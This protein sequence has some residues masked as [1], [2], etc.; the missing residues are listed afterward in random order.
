MSLTTVRW[1]ALGAGLM[2]LAIGEALGGP[3][4]IA[5][6]RRFDQANGNIRKSHRNRNLLALI[7]NRAPHPNAAHQQIQPAA[8]VLVGMLAESAPL[9]A[10]WPQ[11]IKQ[12]DGR[13]LVAFAGR[14]F[15]LQP[16]LKNQ[17]PGHYLGDTIQEGLARLE[18]LLVKKSPAG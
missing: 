10:G 2:P 11:W 8:L 7:I 13:P 4:L 14:A 6:T 18:E 5:A 9:L 3:V 16:E 12:A 1:L 17:V 15:V